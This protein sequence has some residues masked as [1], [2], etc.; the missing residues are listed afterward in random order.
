[1]EGMALTDRGALAAK[2]SAAAAVADATDADIFVV[3]VLAAA[4]DM[5]DGK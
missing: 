1:M 5:L 2:A 4:E 3:T